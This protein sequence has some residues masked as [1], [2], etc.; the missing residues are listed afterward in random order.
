M[1]FRQFMDELPEDV[2]PEA[3]KAEYDRYLASVYGNALRAEFEQ[4]KNDPA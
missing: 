1:T 4:R 3:A 2:T